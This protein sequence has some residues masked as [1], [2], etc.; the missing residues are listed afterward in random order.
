MNKVKLENMHGMRFNPQ[1]GEA[2]IPVITEFVCEGCRNLVKQGDVFCW[3]CG[4][5]LQD[6][7]LIE[8]YGFGGQVDHK[9]FVEAMKLPPLEAA[10]YIKGHLKKG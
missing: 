7:G 8:H 4:D 5:A 3:A 2:E 6:T 1:T 10:E 9:D